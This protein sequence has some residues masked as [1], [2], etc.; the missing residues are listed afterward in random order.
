MDYECLWVNSS[1][2]TEYR[3]NSTLSRPEAPCSHLTTLELRYINFTFKCYSKLP[4]F[5]FRFKS[6]SCRLEED[7]ALLSI[8]I[9]QTLLVGRGLNLVLSLSPK[10][11]QFFPS[12]VLSSHTAYCHPWDGSRSGSGLRYLRNTFLYLDDILPF[13]WWSKHWVQSA[14]DSFHLSSLFPISDPTSDDIWYI[15]RE[16][17]FIK[18][19]SN[20]YCCSLQS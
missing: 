10:C 7:Q 1:K 9:C 2:Y 15:K 12:I 13:L 16:R 4:T 8:R 5:S 14:F 19:Q 11:H 18:S 3:L 20:S 17:L 6:A